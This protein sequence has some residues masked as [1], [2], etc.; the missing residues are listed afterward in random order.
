[1]K[2]IFKYLFILVAV[3]LLFG[4]YVFFPISAQGKPLERLADTTR[5]SH[6]LQVI[7]QTAVS[8]NYKNP[9]VLDSVAAY[10]NR[11]FKKQTNSVSEQKFK[12]GNQE[13]KNVIASFGPENGARI[14]VGAHYD[15]CEEQQGADDN[16]SGTVGLLELA[17]LLKEAKLKYRVDLVAYTLEE[18]PFSEL[19][20]WEVLFMPNHYLIKKSL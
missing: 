6:D 2:P 11:E 9:S 20:L 4:I 12:V 1:M 8:R 7:T 18:P 10:I 13:Y 15:V 14:I 17:R 16:A 5:I 3:F 19:N